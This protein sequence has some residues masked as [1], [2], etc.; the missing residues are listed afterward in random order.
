[1]L[2]CAPALAAVDTLLDAE[3]QRGGRPAVM[4]SLRGQLE[5]LTLL[6]EEIS[7]MACASI[8]RMA[9]EAPLGGTAPAPTQA[10]LWQLHTVACRC[11]ALPGSLPA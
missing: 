4:V 8:S 11:D 3:V 5:Q 2:R 9:A 6:V 7:S 1:M 10:A